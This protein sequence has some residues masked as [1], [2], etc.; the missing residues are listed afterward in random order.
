MK[1]FDKGPQLLRVF[2]SWERVGKEARSATG[3]RLWLLEVSNTVI[4]LS[5]IIFICSVW[6]SAYALT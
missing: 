6:D 1:N 4:P 2:F 3:R 5:K